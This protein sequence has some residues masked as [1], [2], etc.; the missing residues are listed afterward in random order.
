MSAQKPC[1]LIVMT[2]ASAVMTPFAVLAAEENLRVTASATLSSEQVNGFYVGN[3]KPLTPSPLIKLPAGHVEPRGWLR[4]QLVLEADGMV[5]QLTRL[6]NWCRFEGSAWVDPKGVGA[7]G[8]EELPYWLKGYVSLGAVLKNQH[9]LDESHKW[10]DAVMAGQREDG[11]FGPQANKEEHDLWPNMPMLYALRTWYEVTGDARV[12]ECLKRYFRWQTTVPTEHFL[13]KSWQHVRAC[14]NLD[15]VHWLYNQTGEPWLLELATKN[16]KAS[17][18]WVSKIASVHGVNFAECFREPAQFYQQSHDETH[19][20][21][22]ER[23]YD[24][25][26][27]EFGQV[28][29]GMYGA[30]EN[31][32]KGYI[33]PR[34]GSE[35]CAHVEMMHSQQLLLLITG[36]IRWADRCEDIALNTFPAAFTPD[37]KALHYITCPNQVQLDRVNKA[38]MI[39]NDGDMMTYSPYE[40]YRCCQHNV[41][42][43]WPY[44]AE[45]LWMATPGNGLA[46]A[47][48]AAS[49]VKAKVG[50]G[51][52]VTIEE[53]TDYPFGEIITFKIDAPKSVR[54]PLSLR[55][56]G[57]CDGATVKLNGRAVNA[58]P[59]PGQWLTV[60]R[61]WDK[62]DAVELR[63]PM[64]VRLR[65]WAVN[66]NSI[67]VDRGPLTYSLKIGERWEKYTT[68]PHKGET[69]K[70]E[71]RQPR[72]DDFPCWEVFPTT[73]WNYALNVDIKAPEK[74]FVFVDATGGL[75]P[76]PFTPDAAPIALKAK[77]RKFPA[78]K[79]EPNGMIGMLPDS[80]VPS[81]QL[82]PDT[83]DVTL[84]PMGCARL[85]VSA[86]PVAAPGMN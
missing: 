34:Q 42:F 38:P 81:D 33:S 36:D 66:A 85:R 77:A 58:A 10:I 67:S 52:E 44:L 11:Y 73:P 19:L 61:T 39:Q 4:H 31:A 49:G 20:K 8:W 82:A 63:L 13:A 17:A 30:D 28:P 6:S 12:I 76:Q 35:T 69:N 74:S 7:Y 65:T 54:F 26:Y 27:G 78:W 16:H 46:A 50:D 14:D 86:F 15:I 70:P 3:R 2:L 21:A 64:Q 41:A 60:D 80:P 53:I 22:A 32:R 59:R 55:I 84:I 51:T 40:H 72:V 75:K 83:E 47:F 68:T 29:G 18:P 25:Y 1:L 5:G 37:L 79:M 43:G 9:I 45:R 56:P 57:W 48:Y 23:N 71:D 24:E 62:G